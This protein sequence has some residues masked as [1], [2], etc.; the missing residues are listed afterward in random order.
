MQDKINEVR[1]I[2]V[3]KKAYHDFNILQTF[4]AGI[5]LKG[6]EVKSIKD[7]KISFTD[8]FGYI[9]NGEIFLKNVHV[10]QYPFGNRQNHDPLRE[11]KLLLH[12]REI[13]KLR[14]KV[15]EKGLT[16]VPLKVYVKRGR[17]KVVLGLASGKKLAHK[18]EDIKKK[19]QMRE[20]KRDFK[21]SNLSGKLK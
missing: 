4:E 10:S 14:S 3:N 11:R 1:A 9:K 15:K 19:D 5:V 17:I 2:S 7:G 8:G 6:T 12:K 21:L 16:L 18:K 20:L 13:K